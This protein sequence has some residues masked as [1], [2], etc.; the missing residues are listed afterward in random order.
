MLFFTYEGGFMQLYSISDE[1]I[2]YLRKKLLYHCS[3][4]TDLYSSCKEMYGFD[5]SGYGF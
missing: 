2:N 3:G 5:L 4:G 1:Y